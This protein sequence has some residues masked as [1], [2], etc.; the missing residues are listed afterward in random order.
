MLPVRE[1]RRRGPQVRAGAAAEIEDRQLLSA[2]KDAAETREQSFVP[3]AMIRGLAQLQ[4]GGAEPAH[5]AIS[6]STR[7]TLAAVSL[8][9]GRRCPALQDASAKRRR[10]ARSSI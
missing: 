4:P 2:R 3:G 8:Q 5:R 1:M 10:S 9:R 6:R 7:A